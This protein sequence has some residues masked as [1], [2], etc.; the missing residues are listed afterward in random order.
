ML[1]NA[2]QN[3][4]LAQTIFCNCLTKAVHSLREEDLLI[5]SQ[6]SDT[7]HLDT[8]DQVAVIRDTVWVYGLVSFDD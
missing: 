4:V 6:L 3:K 8:C 2:Q 5:V 1:S 7:S